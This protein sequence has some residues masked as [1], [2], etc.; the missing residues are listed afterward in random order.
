L[1]NRG[2]ALPFALFRG[3][4]GYLFICGLLGVFILFILYGI[5]SAGPKPVGTGQYFPQYVFADTL[6]G[7]E[8]AYL[9][10][11]AGKNLSIRNIRAAVIIVEMFNTYCTICPRDVPVMNGLSSLIE[12]DPKLRAKIKVISIAVGNTPAEITSYKKTHGARYPIL[13]DPKFALHRLLGDPRV[14]YTVIINKNKIAY[15]H[16]GVIDSSESLLDL[17]VRYLDRD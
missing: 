1:T 9:G 3:N 16:H 2:K 15:T 5:A 13:S 12:K 10:I 7:D 14:P 8:R 11:S 4:T 17:A 6:S